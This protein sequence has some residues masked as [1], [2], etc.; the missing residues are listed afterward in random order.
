MRKKKINKKAQPLIYTMEE[1]SLWDWLPPEL[2][3][4]V[5]QYASLQSRLLPCHAEIRSRYYYDGCDTHTWPMCGYGRVTEELTYVQ[6]R[7]DPEYGLMRL[8]RGVYRKRNLDLIRGEWLSKNGNFMRHA[9]MEGKK[10]CVDITT[11]D[12]PKYYS[13]VGP[14]DDLFFY[15]RSW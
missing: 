7:K 13:M 11:S 4:H 3:E 10:Y 12:I 2:Q 9:I 14:N 1:E 8:Y 5:L 15:K 6:V